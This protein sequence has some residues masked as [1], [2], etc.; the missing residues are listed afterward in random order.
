MSVD[1]IYMYIQLHCIHELFSQ[2]KTQIKNKCRRGR[3]RDR[4]VV[5]CMTTYA[6][7]AYHH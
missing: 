2:N 4:M 3:D 6:I 1:G 5:E 7:S